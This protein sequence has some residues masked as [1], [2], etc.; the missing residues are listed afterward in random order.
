MCTQQLADDTATFTAALTDAS[1]TATGCEAQ[2][3]IDATAFADTLAAAVAETDSCSAELVAHTTT[4]TN[5]LSAANANTDVCV[6]SLVTM[7]TSR[8]TCTGDLADAVAATN[9]AQATVTARGTTISQ[10]T[11]AAEQA[12]TSI[13]ASEASLATMTASRDSCTSDLADTVAAANTAHAECAASLSAADAECTATLGQA[14]YYLDGE[15]LTLCDPVVG[16]AAVTCTAAGNSVAVAAPCTDTCVDT[17]GWTVDGNPVT[18]CDWIAHVCNPMRRGECFEQGGDTACQWAYVQSGH[19]IPAA[20]CCACQGFQIPENA[21]MW[22]GNAV[23]TGNWVEPAGSDGTSLRMCEAN[24]TLYQHGLGPGNDAPHAHELQAQFCADQGQRLCTYQELCPTGCGDTTY[25]D[26][27]HS[28]V[29][30]SGWYGDVVNDG[31]SWVFVGDDGSPPCR[32]HNSRRAH[33][34]CGMENPA[35]GGGDIYGSGVYCC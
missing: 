23:H 8:D 24:P 7:T 29:P 9:A 31:N 34:E 19:G 14:G 5:S 17:P 27:G 10:M 12:Q 16:A 32:D 28:W 21:A 33:T 30:Y 11:A 25:Q 6:A 18:T 4:S 22:G 2:R 15:T 35:W 13:S 1:T 3:I 20:N 26:A